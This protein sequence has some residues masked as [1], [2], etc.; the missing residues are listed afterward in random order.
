M[1]LDLKA[2][3]LVAA[4]EAAESSAKSKAAFLANMS[5]EIRTP[6]NSVI[7]FVELVLE[8]SQI[9]PDQG[10]YLRKALGSAKN[11]LSLINEIL[12][13]SKMEAGKLSLENRPLQL[14]RFIRSTVG[15]HSLAI[16]RKGLALHVHI[17]PSLTVCIV[18]DID[19]LRRVLINLLDN[20]V[21]F[22]EK[23]SV[24][25]TLTDRSDGYIQFSIADTGIGL[26]EEEKSAIF[27]P[28]TQAD[29]SIAR[30]Y[31][32][33]GLGTTISQELIHLMGGE[34]WVDSEPGRGSTFHFTLPKQVI[35]CP[36]EGSEGYQDFLDPQEPTLF[37]PSRRF[38]ILMAE[39]V[40]ENA[41]LAAVRLEKQ[42]HQVRTV[43]NGADAVAS[44]REEAFDLILMDIHMPGMDG[45]AATRKIRRISPPSAVPV[46]IIALTASVMEEDR[47]LYKEAGISGV[48]GKPISFQELFSLMEDLVPD[49]YGEPWR[50]EPTEEK[51][52]EGLPVPPLDQTKALIM[53]QYPGLYRKALDSFIDKYRN[54][55]SRLNRLI[56]DGEKEEAYRLAHNLKGLSGT[57]ALTKLQI[58]AGVLDSALKKGPLDPH[59]PKLE[60][61]RDDLK[62]AVAAIEEYLKDEPPVPPQDQQEPQ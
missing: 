49:G 34:I 2:I 59:D 39:D 29:Q 9:P 36:E 13:I 55:S 3:E 17:P 26:T 14:P 43:S 45:L 53:W 19:K 20:A 52:P 11:L 21:K 61:V 33:T 16:E 35:P 27:N 12:E 1:H 30:L 25:V 32:G 58:S 8:N 5:H 31:G 47:K 56:R 42:G 57:L 62:E 10:D 22:T 41:A 37:R 50:T 40:E 24:T 4:K 23:G 18:A 54:A 48:I 60:I 38:K 46:P 15:A 51:E 7:G 6:L 28:F 44:Y